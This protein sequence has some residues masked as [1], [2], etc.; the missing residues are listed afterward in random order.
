MDFGFSEE[1]ELLRQEVRKFLS[2]QCPMEEVRRIM[3]EPLGYS[4][5]QWLSLSQLGW[6]G[7]IIPEDLGGVGLGWV[8]LIVL[9]E[10]TGRTLFPSPLISSVLTSATLL[11]LGS[12]AQQRHWL[13][14]FADGSHIGALAIFDDPDRLEPEGITLEA[15]RE[16]EHYVLS[17]DK[18]GVVDAVSANLFVVGFRKPDGGMA[19]AL[20]EAESPG[21][22]VEA[23][24]TLDESKRIGTLHLDSVRVADDALLDLSPGDEST[25]LQAILDRG[26][27]AV[28]AEILGAG[29]AALALTVQYAKDR[30]QFGHPIGHFQ[31]VK[32]PCAEMYVDLE[33]IK[34]LLYYA[35]WALDVSPDEVSFSASKT[36]AFASEAFARIGVDGVQ[37]HGAVGYTEEYD[38]QLFLKRSKWSRPIFGDEDYH[39]ERVATMGGL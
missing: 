20:I 28:A 9:L 37:L 26:A 36:K 39:L 19:L 14:G 1:Q 4:R 25:A 12:S 38:I 10:E 31:G 23:K 34:S 17:G 18:P 35:A 21:L 13:P 8:D 32:H 3:K 24:N 15:Q 30:T 5:E 11:E 22:Q 16:G 33:C 2:E 27:V 6:T 29:E 7:L